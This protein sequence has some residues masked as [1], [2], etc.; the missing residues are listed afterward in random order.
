[1]F[2]NTIVHEVGKPK[3]NEWIYRLIK[4]PKLNPEFRKLNVSIVN[5]VVECLI[6]DFQLEMFRA[7]RIYS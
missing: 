3:R 6:K 1:M 2:E 5:A 7:R 4:P